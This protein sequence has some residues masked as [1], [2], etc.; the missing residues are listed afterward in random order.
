ML[1]TAQKVLESVVAAGVKEAEV[2]AQEAN[3]LKISVYR[4][5]VEELASS[6][7]RG[8]GVRAIVDGAVGYAYTTDMSDESLAATAKAAADNASVAGSDEFNGLPQ[9][10]ES[11][12]DLELHS[13]GLAGTALTDKIDIARNMEYEALKRDARVAKVEASQYVEADSRVAIASSAGINRE[14]R[15]G[16]CYAFLQAIVEQEGEMQTGIA[17]TTGR[18][19]SQLS[20]ADCGREAA[21][22]ALMLLGGSQCDSMSCPVV[23]DPFVTASL[24]SVI[25]SMLSAEAV[26]KHR[27]MFAGS[28]GKP[29]ASDMV[30]LVDDGLH[31]DG[32]ASSPFDGEGVPCR[33]TQLIVDGVLQGFLH[34]T[35]TAGKAGRNST[36][37]AARGSYRSLPHVGTTNL[38]LI[39]GSGSATEIIAQV[40]SG[41]FVTGV[42]GIHSGA[43]PVSGDFSVG[44]T[45]VLIKGGKLADPVREITIAGNLLE[46][47][48]GIQA[49]ADDNRWI[50]F[51]GSIHAP[52]I[53]IEEMTISGK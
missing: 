44:A 33:S 20:S 36:G 14:Y 24:F 2:F 18:E 10:A 9:P 30:E 43:N 50:P 28:E 29:V 35:Y 47:L 40:D 3:S 48:K 25:G 51:G 8:L 27:S 23:M 4:G 52:T 7:G 39:G 45:G 1:T 13:A 16:A 12:P 6:T 38:R 22:R 15:E 31:P 53:M 34:D 41:L 26:Q 49:V 37:N 21:D 19:P 46:I 5:D 32:L 42:S 11:Y 17:F